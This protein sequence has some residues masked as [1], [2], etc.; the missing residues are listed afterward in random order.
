MLAE[1]NHRSSKVVAGASGSGMDGQDPV[2]DFPEAA[3][4]LLRGLFQIHQQIQSDL[5][6][7]SCMYGIGSAKEFRVV[8]LGCH[9]GLWW[10]AILLV[11]LARPAL[12]R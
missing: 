5:V 12:N 7:K 3:A 10:M 6:E 1:P 11:V 9:V 2:P 4:L 8:P